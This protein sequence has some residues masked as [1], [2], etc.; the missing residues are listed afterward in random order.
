MAK[1][2]QLIWE[3][4]YW[5]NG[6]CWGD[7]TIILGL[8][9]RN[10]YRNCKKG[11]FPSGTYSIR[12]IRHFD[13]PGYYGRSVVMYQVSTSPRRRSWYMDFTTY[14]EAKKFAT[15]ILKDRT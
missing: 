15:N 6:L 4:I 8:L 11:C 5:R 12:K 13:T 1:R 3:K 7:P 9:K 10:P 2:N 14:S